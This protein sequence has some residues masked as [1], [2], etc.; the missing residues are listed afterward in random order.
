MG[1]R[2]QIARGGG[3][4]GSHDG[5]ESLYTSRSTNLRNLRLEARVV[6]EE[7]EVPAADLRRD[8]RFTKNELRMLIT[9]DALRMLIT[10]DALKGLII[11]D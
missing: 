10:S 11:S 2:G 6:V 7:P 1:V 3:P 4:A 9:S 5:R 8:F